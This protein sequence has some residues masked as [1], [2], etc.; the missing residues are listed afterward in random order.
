M[1]DPGQVPKTDQAKQP[2]RERVWAAL[3]AAGAVETG[4]AG[5]IPD[6]RGADQAAGRLAALPVWQQARVL[7]IVP[8][9][10]QLPV[11]IL[12]LEQGKLVYMAAPKLATPEPFYVLDPATLTISPTEAAQREIAARTAAT[13]D[14]DGMQHIDLVIVGSVAVN[15]KGAR[16]GKGAGY[17]DIELGLLSE[18]G[19]VTEGTTICTTVHEHQVLDEELPELRHDFRVDLIATPQRIIW[20]SEPRRPDSVDWSGLSPAQIAAI[21]V[22]KARMHPS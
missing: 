6:F 3:E 11:R 21:P 13:T 18:A 9:R 12:A 4:V 14:V 1:S 15:P 10:A 17:S 8:D 5:Y 16:L 22:L 2:I 20:C 19:L 7:K